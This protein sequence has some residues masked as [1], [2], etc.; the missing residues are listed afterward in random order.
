VKQS[1]SK[2]GAHERN[3]TGI[4][5]AYRGARAGYN[6]PPRQGRN[7]PQHFACNDGPRSEPDERLLASQFGISEIVSIP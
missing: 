7:G 1:N 2:R 5:P 4:A 6:G 3:D